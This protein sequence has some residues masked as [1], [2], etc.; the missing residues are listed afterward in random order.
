MEQPLRRLSQQVKRKL[1][2]CFT[3][4]KNE[5]NTCNHDF[6]LGRVSARLNQ[7][8]RTLLPLLLFHPPATVVPP[9]S[10]PIHTRERY[11][12]QQS[13]TLQLP[14]EDPAVSLYSVPSMLSLHSALDEG[15]GTAEDEVRGCGQLP[16]ATLLRKYPPC[17]DKV[18]SFPG[19][20]RKKAFRT[21]SD[22]SCAEA[23]ERG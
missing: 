18:A 1:R 12:R 5:Y 3:H 6:S 22:K 14:P 21:A 2:L 16:S 15:T 7:Q 20:P 9:S 17:S 8:L 4:K 19:S 13:D 10:P 23:W 11:N